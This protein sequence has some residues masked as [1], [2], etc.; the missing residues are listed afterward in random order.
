M[1]AGA[2]LLVTWNGKGPGTRDDSASEHANG[3]IK[4][5]TIVASET[6]LL[7]SSPVCTSVKLESAG[8]YRI[9]GPAQLKTKWPRLRGQNIYIIRKCCIAGHRRREW[10]GGWNRSNG[11]CS[12]LWGWAQITRIMVIILD[13]MSRRTYFQ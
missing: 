10:E 4:S 1:S 13:I 7:L 5:R 2:E 12:G 8:K 3:T 6:C 11:W 9:A